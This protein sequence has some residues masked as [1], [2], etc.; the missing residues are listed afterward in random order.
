MIR[1]TPKSI[2]TDTILP[3][4]TLFRSQ[5]A[6]A[7][8]LLVETARRDAQVGAFEIGFGKAGEARKLTADLRSFLAL[9]FL[10]LEQRGGIGA[11]RPLPGFLDER[12]ARWRARL[13]TIERGC[14]HRRE[15]GDRRHLDSR[16]VGARRQ[17]L[18]RLGERPG[19]EEGVSMSR[20]QLWT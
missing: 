18:H 14:A 10:A 4:P 16:R 11:D 1:R 15:A 9:Q 19:G 17:L 6:V 2:R 20:S 8:Q 7:Q 5:S 3:Y 12:L 13:P